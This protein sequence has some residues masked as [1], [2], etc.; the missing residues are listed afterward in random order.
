NADLI[1]TNHALLFSD[2]INEHQLLPAYQQAVI[3]EAHHLEDIAT[4]FFGIKTDYFSILQGFVRMGL[5]DGDGIYGKVLS[6]LRN[7]GVEI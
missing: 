7:L 2:L 4:E 5:K 1:I 3:D 6:I